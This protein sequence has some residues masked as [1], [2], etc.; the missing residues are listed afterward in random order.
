[1]IMKSSSRTV[2][3][4]ADVVGI[5]DGDDDARSEHQLLPGFLQVDDVDAGGSRAFIDVFC[6]TSIKTR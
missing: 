4:D 3:D 1:M 5:L 2:G 6:D